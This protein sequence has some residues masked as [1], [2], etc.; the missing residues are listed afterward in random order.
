MVPP[1][2]Q[3]SNIKNKLS[4]NQLGSLAKYQIKPRLDAESIIYEK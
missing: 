1:F 3:C 4:K 2:D